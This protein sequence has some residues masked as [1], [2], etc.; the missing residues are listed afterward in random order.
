MKKTKYTAVG[1]MSGTS[2][3]SIDASA[4]QVDL[5]NQKVSLETIG[6]LSYPIPECIRK[7]IFGLFKDSGGSLC[8]LAVLN[9]RLGYLFAEAV[10]KLLKR[11]GLK[12]DDITVIG[13]H[14]QTIYHVADPLELCGKMVRGTIQTGEASVIAQETGIPV[15]SDFRTADIAAGGSGAPLVPFLDIILF[16]NLNKNIA[17]QNIGGIG[18]VTWIPGTGDSITAFDTGPGNMIIDG[19]V[20]IFTGG[21]YRYDKNCFIG[22]QGKVLQDVLKKWM[23]HPYFKQKPPKTTG[24]EEFGNKFLK[25]ELNNIKVTPD[26]IRT[27]EELT[28]CSIADSYNRFLPE[29]PE[30]VIVTGGGAHN[31]IIIDSLKK[32][33]PES[34]VVTGDEYGIDPDFKEAAAFALM[35]LWTIL[36]KK[37]NVPKAT[38]ANRKIIMG[39]ISYP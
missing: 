39:K 5:D 2:V 9:I 34:E 1:L 14:G 6:N 12:P 21:K 17:A 38:G 22:K 32:Y 27:A 25:E 3:D 23:E 18:N 28:A 26:V 33:L 11:T 31:S 7:Q 15:A 24:R 36:R 29:K 4:V 30:T 37:N 35:G 13:S 10:T 8:N 20:N 16:K 19:L